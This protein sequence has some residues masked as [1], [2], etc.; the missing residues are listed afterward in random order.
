MDEEYLDDESIVHINLEDGR[1]FSVFLYEHGLDAMLYI[2]ATHFDEFKGWV[3]KDRRV[4]GINYTFARSFFEH[5]DDS[6]II[7]ASIDR[8]GN[9][10]FYQIPR[11]A[12]GKSPN[13]LNRCGLRSEATEEEIEWYRE[14]V[15]KLRDSDKIPSYL[16]RQLLG[17]DRL[18]KQLELF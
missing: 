10:E 15:G 3:R 17:E 5:P 13:A 1:T 6:I 11:Y 2:P 18:P 9:A 14:V 7:S 12:P 8:D 16:A 4:K